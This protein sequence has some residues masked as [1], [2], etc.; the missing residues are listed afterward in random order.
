MFGKTNSIEVARTLVNSREVAR[1]RVNFFMTKK[2]P[3]DR[4]KPM[5]Y[6]EWSKSCELARTF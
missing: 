4:R 1:T 5:N 6:E 3:N 2:T